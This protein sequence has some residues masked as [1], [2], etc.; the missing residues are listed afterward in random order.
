MTNNLV[1]NEVNF[2]SIQVVGGFNIDIKFESYDG[3]IICNISNYM[4]EYE[5]YYFNNKMIT[6]VN[7]VDSSNEN[8]II[9]FS[10]TEIDYGKM[11][12]MIQVRIPIYKFASKIRLHSLNLV[13]G[14]IY[15]NF[16]KEYEYEVNKI[17]IT[18]NIKNYAYSYN[19]IDY[20]TNIENYSVPNYLIR[21]DI[22]YTRE[23][24]PSPI[25]ILFGYD[26]YAYHNESYYILHIVR[27]E[28]ENKSIKW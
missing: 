20:F 8:N 1:Y 12:N 17:E 25:Q 10:N 26:Y 22:I 9:S 23:L 5:Y 3:Y 19:Y 11:D 4:D 28:F 16:S 2:G 7:F 6:S 13:N 27:Y 15:S 21:E 14:G 18:S 24:S